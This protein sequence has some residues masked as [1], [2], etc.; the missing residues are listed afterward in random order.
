VPSATW[1]VAE[2][3][4]RASIERFF[5]RMVIFLHLQRPP[6]FGW[7]TVKTRVALTYAAVWVITLAAWHG[8]RPD[9]IRSPRRIL[10]RA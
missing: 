3:G 8:C 6:I 5:G 1:T 10:A 7:P 9:L 4:K 2:L